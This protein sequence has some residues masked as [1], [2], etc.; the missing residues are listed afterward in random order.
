MLKVREN[1][2]NLVGQSAEEI[3]TRVIEAAMK[4]QVASAKYLFEAVGLYPA[5]EETKAKDPKESLAYA[6]LKRLGLPAEAVICDEN[7]Q[8]GVAASE[9]ARKEFA[10]ERER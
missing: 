5:R 10:E 7:S 1:I 6:L 8:A 3:V 9:D 2:D 4:G